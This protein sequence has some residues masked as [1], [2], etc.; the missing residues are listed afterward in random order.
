[1]RLSLRVRGC[2]YVAGFT[3]FF[4]VSLLLAVGLGFSNYFY[5]EKQ[6]AMVDASSEMAELYRT[7]GTQAE[8]KLDT[9]CR[10]SGLDAIIVDNRQLVYSSRPGGRIYIGRT[11]NLRTDGRQNPNVVVAPGKKNDSDV[12]LSAME[13]PPM[14]I[15]K[16]LEIMNGH[17]PLEVELNHVS[18]YKADD[19]FQYFYLMNRIDDNCYLLMIE[20][21]RPMQDSIYIFQ[22]FIFAIGFAMLFIAILWS[23]YSSR[24]LTTPLL[25]LRQLSVAMTK[26]DFSKKWTRHRDDEIGQL[27]TS[28]NTLSDQLSTALQE[29]KES[30]AQLQEQLDK[31]KEV[32]HMRKSFLSAVSHELKTPL[33]L[34]QGYAEGLDSLEVDEDTRRRYCR[35]IHLETEKM[36]KLVKDLLN[37]SR[38]ETGSFHIERTAFDFCAL[39][40][41]AR[42][43]FA[44]VIEEKDVAMTWELF[45][46]MTVNGDPERYDTILSNYISNAI[47]YTP[48]GKRIIISAT[49]EGAT[50]RI[51]VYNDGIQIPVEYQSRIWEPF[52]KVDESRARTNGRIFGGHGLG[53]GIV[54]ALVKLHGQQYG[55]HNEEH[56]VTF[57]FTIAKEQVE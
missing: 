46:E 5:S 13:K 16:M 9:I 11:R 41:E 21:L 17:N 29:L 32:E 42:E 39:A 52:Y 27:G 38:L 50:Y 19:Q 57:W 48:A 1:M 31:A 34:I 22:K 53:L 56:G 2:L 15:Q 24:K 40:D 49:D 37:L 33:A 23:L 18:F 35:V 8:E 28:L 30:N 3:I 54:A 10:D 4:I 36:D 25:E 20:P 26:L 7:E 14:H 43:R 12:A 55:V 45:P 6:S 51:S 44:K 47:D